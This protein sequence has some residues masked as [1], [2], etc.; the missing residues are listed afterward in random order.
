ML[1]CLLALLGAGTL[2]EP[3]TWDAADPTTWPD[4]WR[5][6]DVPG[7]VKPGSP[8]FEIDLAYHLGD[9][10]GCRQMAEQGIA[11]NPND[12]EL[13]WL[14]A[15]CIFDHA[16]ARPQDF[17][18]VDKEAY[19][20]DMLSWVDRGLAVAPNDTRL[21]WAR[22]LA[23]GRYGTSRGVLSTLFYADDVERAWL[24][25]AERPVTYRTLAAEVDLPC[26]VYQTLG[27]YYRIVPDSWAVEVIAGTRGSLDK[28]RQW[29]EKAEACDATVG[30]L[31]EHGAT[32]IC[33]GQKRDDDK[34]IEAGRAK[35]LRAAA[36]KPIGNVEKVDVKHAKMLLANPSL[37]CGYSRDGQQDQDV[38]KLKAAE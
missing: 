22:G 3:R 6:R 25:A 37:A 28:S 34:L 23:L 21:L 32:L 20:Q 15:L 8:H 26:D 35:L 7:Q 4:T 12:G 29:L 16:E 33:T 2:V 9:Y 17:V 36:I 1:L 30:I 14:I 27:I 10:Q 24:Q 31:K 11:A 5:I 13:Y 18:N 19:Y 38:S